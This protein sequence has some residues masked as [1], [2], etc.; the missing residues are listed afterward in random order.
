VA[1]EAFKHYIISR[2]PVLVYITNGHTS[3]DITEMM[4]HNVNQ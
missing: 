4:M 3:Q 2:S 1:D